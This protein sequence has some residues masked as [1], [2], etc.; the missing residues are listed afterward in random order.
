[1]SQQ[2][3]KANVSS[4]I[5]L[6]LSLY[7]FVS[8]PTHPLFFSMRVY[9]QMLEDKQDFQSCSC[10]TECCD[11]SIKK[12]DWLFYKVELKWALWFDSY[13]YILKY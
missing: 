5:R 1:M 12:R 6:L 13:M 8:I 9:Q 7:F 2:S 3:I 4:L 10:H 11:A